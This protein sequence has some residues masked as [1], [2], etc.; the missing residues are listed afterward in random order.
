MVFDFD[1][2]VRANY[3][4]LVLANRVAARWRP[5]LN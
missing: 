3:C 5:K 2:T 1:E 4:E